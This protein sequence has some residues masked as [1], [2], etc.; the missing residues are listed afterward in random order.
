MERIPLDRPIPLHAYVR[1]AQ[2][3]FENVVLT[4]TD[5]NMVHI[6]SRD[7]T[8]SLIVLPSGRCEFDGERAEDFELVAYREFLCL[9]SSS[10]NLLLQFN[11]GAY[12]CLINDNEGPGVIVF[13]NDNGNPIVPLIWCLGLGVAGAAMVPLIG[14]GAAALVPTAMSTYGTVV[15]GV[16]TFHAPLAAGGVA[17]IL[18]STSATLM[19]TNAAAVGAAVGTL[20]G[21]KRN[22]NENA[23]RRGGD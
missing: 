5:G 20:L 11:D 18:Q 3:A 23:E 4:A 19:T 12:H 13:R 14:L 8:R 15:A 6:Q 1:E 16:G 9:R 7:R 22:G 2:N 17:A 21:L 10:T